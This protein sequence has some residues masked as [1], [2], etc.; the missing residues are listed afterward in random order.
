[1]GKEALTNLELSELEYCAD[2]FS[3]QMYRRCT[4]NSKTLE[5]LEN[6][7]GLYVYL[8]PF[9]P[10]RIYIGSTSRAPLRHQ[11][12]SFSRRWAHYFIFYELTDYFDPK[13]VEEVILKN[14]SLHLPK[15]MWDNEK[16]IHPKFATGLNSHDPEMKNIATMIF[17]HL[18]TVI[19]DYGYDPSGL[20][21]DITHEFKDPDGKS[22]GIAHIKRNGYVYIL[23]RSMINSDYPNMKALEKSEKALV[24]LCKYYHE[25]MIYRQRE[26]LRRPAGYMVMEPIK[27]RGKDQAARFLMAS[28]TASRSWWRA[29]A[30]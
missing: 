27:F 10:T 4:L 1:M 28:H 9:G 14:A 19:Y 16:Y 20:D 2:H 3:P 8:R 26:T 25:G 23:K 17:D 22:N 7:S 5:K 24:S 29:V 13:I 11:E 15:M 6:R 18:R 21:M 12:Q 30:K